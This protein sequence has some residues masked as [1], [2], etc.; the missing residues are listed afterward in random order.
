MKFFGLCL[1]LLSWAAGIYMLRKWR[2]LRSMSI[3][4]HAASNPAALRLFASVLIAGGLA[5]YVWLVRWFAPELNLSALF[6]VLIT[7]TFLTQIV[8]ALIPDTKGWRSST[9]RAAA[10]SGAFLY[11][12]LSYLILT[13]PNISGPGKIV[14]LVCFSYMILACFLYLFVKKSH[15]H[16][17]IFQALYIMAFQVIIL[18]A[19]YAQR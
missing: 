13:A 17:V 18:S 11:L 4:Q 10:Y 7:A 6:V 16:Y 2:G 1:V 14:G 3:S 9:H 8:A 19:A 15:D 12:P 5:F